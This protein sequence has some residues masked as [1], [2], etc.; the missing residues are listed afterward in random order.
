MAKVVYYSPYFWPETIGSAPYCTDVA[1][2]L[3][4]GGHDV[5]VLAF[6]PHYPNIEQFTA[7]YESHENKESYKGIRV[8]RVTPRVRSNGGFN[9]R[10]RNDLRFLFE[11]LRSAWA[12]DTAS[13][14]A[15][16]AYIPSILCG[17]A[18]ALVARRRGARLIIIVHDIES[19]LAQSL[20]IVKNRVVLQAMRWLERNVLSCADEVVVLTA[21]MAQELAYIGCEKPITVLPIWSEV[22]PERYHNR[23]E[24]K[25][26]YSGNF[27]KKQGLDQLLPLIC[28]MGKTHP[29]IEF[30]LRGEGSEKERLIGAVRSLGCNNVLFAGLAPSDQLIETLQDIDIHLV[31]QA[32]NVANYAVPSK[33]FSVMA[34]GRPFICIAEAGSPLSEIVERSRGGVC[35]D[36]RSENALLNAVLDLVNHPNKRVEMGR[37]GRSY[38]SRYMDREKILSRYTELVF[39]KS[40]SIHLHKQ[41]TLEDRGCEP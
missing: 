24:I 12:P 28:S 8:K 38:I 35:V 30:V 33:V 34:A 13:A 17:L 39:G 22:S 31:P 6:K 7:W 21:R 9:E 26:G 37:N 1:L 20:G 41:N 5:V 32:P 19:G 29:K 3:N 4:A 23:S 27:G 40:R 10:L 16:V 14:E 15:V 2:A 18:A 25:I 11:A 36:V